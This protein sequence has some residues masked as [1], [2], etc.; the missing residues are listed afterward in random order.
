MATTTDGKTVESAPLYAEE[1]KLGPLGSKRSVID[2]DA[3]LRR[4]LVAEF[5]TAA[6]DARAAAAGV[7]RNITTAVHEYRKALRRAR[8]VLLPVVRTFLKI[9]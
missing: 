7:D 1:D 4:V 3:E 8:A 9:S 5:Q 2:D 6:D